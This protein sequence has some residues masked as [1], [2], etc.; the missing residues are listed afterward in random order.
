[1]EQVK[2]FV[3]VQAQRWREGFPDSIGTALV[4]HTTLYVTE[5]SFSHVSIMMRSAENNIQYCLIDLN[6]ILMHIS[7]I[8]RQQ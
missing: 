2:R 5:V 8:P 6:I 4:I 3:T 7:G 1:M